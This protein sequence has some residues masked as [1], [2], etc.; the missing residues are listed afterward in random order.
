M[1]GDYG[2]TSGRTWRKRL[3]R[4][5]AHDDAINCNAAEDHMRRIRRLEAEMN[6]RF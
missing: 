4:L 2:K 6:S 1:S 5:K 3:E